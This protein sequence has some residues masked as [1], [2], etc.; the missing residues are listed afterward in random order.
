[1]YQPLSNVPLV[2]VVL[3]TYNRGHTVTRAIDSVLQQTYDRIELIVVDGAS[4]DDT[5]EQIQQYGNQVRYVRQMTNRGASAARNV[6]IK[7]SEGEFIAFIDSDD[8][9]HSKKVE[10]QVGAFSKLSSDVGVIYTGYYKQTDSGQE[11]GE[12]PSKRGDIFQAQLMKDWVN[13]T[14]TVMVRAE[15]FDEVDGFNTEFEG[16]EDYELWTRLARHYRYDYIKEPLVTLYVDNKQRI[17]NDVKNR[18]EAHRAVLN[19]IRG[20]INDLS[21]NRRRKVLA[22]QHYTMGRYLQSQGRFRQARSHLIKS[23]RFNPMHWKASLALIL[24]VMGN[25]TNGGMFISIKN[26][27]RKHWNK[28]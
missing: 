6:G 4:N 24:A 16:R 21:W 25:D 27:V 19:S 8:E 3:P 23:V 20:D 12:I 13:P 10:K 17:T 28:I 22:M 11:L 5:K 7:K 2:S 26:F 18:M 14:S 1:M 15:C 9:W